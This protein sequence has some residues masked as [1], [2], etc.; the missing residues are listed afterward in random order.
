[1]I[2]SLVITGCTKNS[3]SNN[4]SA[5]TQTV[6][7]AEL[8]PTQ[9]ISNPSVSQPSLQS[10]LSSI[11]GAACVP[12]NTKQQT[13]YVVE[14]IDGDTIDIEIDGSTYRL[15]YI[16]MDTPEIGMPGYEE[17]V[18][19]NRSLVEGKEVLLVM[20]E[21]ETDPY[22]RLLRYVFVDDVFVNYELVRAGF[23]EAGFW[24]PDTSCSQSFAEVEKRSGSM[25]SDL[26]E[27]ISETSIAE[28]SASGACPE[29]CTTPPQGCVIKG[30]INKEGV[31]I[32]HVP[33]GE[34]YEK[35]V[36]SPEYGERWFCTEAEAQANGW[37][38]SMQ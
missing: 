4:I 13:A 20:D 30:N 32:Y 9:T 33:E 34:Y 3:I 31:K 11:R 36:I 23:A 15:R 22:G 24:P 27:V 18:D 19:Y 37:R 25:R 28:Q 1:M 35:T 7:T 5:P 6:S 38:K 10:D 16:G 29:G 14:I 2:M 8:S 21:S 12:E 26:V 17:A